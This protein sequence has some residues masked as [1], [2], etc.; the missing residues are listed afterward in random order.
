[1]DMIKVDKLYYINLDRRL[2]RREHIENVVSKINVGNKSRISAFDFPKNGS[3][4]CA[5][6]HISVL[7]DAIKN[8]FDNIIILE[9]DF[10]AYDID[11]LNKSLFDFFE[12]DISYDVLM[13]SSN[14]IKYKKIDMLNIIRIDEGQTASGYCVNK[15]FINKLL[16]NFKESSNFLK[17]NEQNKYRWAIDQNWKSLQKDNIFLSFYPQLGKQIYSFSDIEERNVDYGV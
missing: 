6:S 8:D 3:Y 7:E 9:D 14:I 1:M 11:I 15:K 10:E 2:D 16:I 13:I 17:D 4:G 5:L 12:S